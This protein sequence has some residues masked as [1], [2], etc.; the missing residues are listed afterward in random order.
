M[1][2]LH[3]CTQCIWLDASHTTELTLFLF[4]LSAVL[5]VCHFLPN[6]KDNDILLAK[7]ERN[8]KK[9]HATKWLCRTWCIIVVH[10]TAWPAEERLLKTVK[11]WRRPRCCCWCLC[12]TLGLN[13]FQL[14]DSFIYSTWL[15]VPSQTIRHAHS[16]LIHQLTP[17]LCGKHVRCHAKR[18]VF[19]ID[20]AQNEHIAR[21]VH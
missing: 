13:S 5:W 7:V 17:L 6:K 20:Y 8:E 18:I 21:S 14:T 16:R 15:R 12:E 19:C 3:K 1:V 10:T 9:K 4:V 11:C 2:A